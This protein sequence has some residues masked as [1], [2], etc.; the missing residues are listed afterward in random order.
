MRAL[1]GVGVLVRGAQGADD[2]GQGSH[3]R[4]QARAWRPHGAGGRAVAGVLVVVMGAGRGRW[5]RRSATRGVAS[6]VAR[7]RWVAEAGGSVRADADGGGGTE[8]PAHGIVE[9]LLRAGGGV[10]GGR[11]AGGSQGC[12]G[13]GVALELQ[14][15]V[16]GA[17]DRGGG[18]PRR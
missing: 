1:V 7:C 10:E 16:K 15:E 6:T 3:D 8:L 9:E 4:T 5:S 18:E 2:G 12:G 17:A 14:G 13:A 11:Q